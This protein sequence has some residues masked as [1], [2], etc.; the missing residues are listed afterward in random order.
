MQGSKYIQSDVN[1]VYI[2]IRQLLK[3]N[4]CVL[5][6]GTPCQVR[7]LKSFLEK[8]YTNLYTMDFLC[9]G[10]SSIKV[11]EK[12]L[13][14]SYPNKRVK[15]ISFRDK[16]FYGWSVNMHI[17]FDDETCCQINSQEDLWWKIYLDNIMLGTQ[18]ADNCRYCRN[19][20]A[21]ITVGDFWGIKDYVKRQ[22]YDDGRGTSVIII[23]TEKGQQIFNNGKKEFS[24]C[25]TVSFEE[26]SRRN[27]LSERIIANKNK[28]KEFFIRLNSQR[29]DQ[30]YYDIKKENG[31]V[32][33]V[34]L[35]F[36]GNYGGALTGWALYKTI[37]K[38]GYTPLLIDLEKGRSLGSQ[39]GMVES[40]IRSCCN[41][42]KPYKDLV[43]LKELN[44]K[45]KTFLV[46][47]DQCWRM[48]FNEYYDYALLLKFVDDKNR[49]LSFATSMES[50]YIEGSLE[51]RMIVGKLLKRFDQIS[52]RERDSVSFLKNQYN[53]EAEFVLDPIFLL[54]DEEWGKLTD[55]SLCPKEQYCA[56][57]FLDINESLLEYYNIIKEKLKLPFIVLRGT[58]SSNPLQIQF[59]KEIENASLP[60]MVNLIKEAKYLVT[61][62][63]HGMCLAIVF[64]IP[65]TV[66]INERRGGT[67]FRS[68]L[69]EFNLENRAVNI[70]FPVEQPNTNE[71]CWNKVEDTLFRLQSFSKNWLCRALVTDI[72]PRITQSEDQFQTKEVLNLINNLRKENE[73]M[74]CQIAELQ[75]ELIRPREERILAYLSQTIENGAQIAYR[76]GGFHTVRLHSL[77]K[78]LL[79]IKNVSV[80]FVIDQKVSNSDLAQ[81][82]TI[83][84][85][86]LKKYHA[87]YILISSAKYRKEMLKELKNFDEKV[88]DIYDLFESELREGQAYYEL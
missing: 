78:S 53:V 4:K 23:N 62:S 33:I 10:V 51:E 66:I 24:K 85:G 17:S 84:V 47:S 34:G 27:I 50:A 87:D 8:D 77:I 83:A 76:G 39:T 16:T 22:K 60:Q 3:Q 43:D 70:T 20:G 58:D 63:F 69:R 48:W 7:A 82:P 86:E 29:L 88:I 57:Y 30:L 11:L 18:C 28:R 64:R 9:H 52:V 31:N 79:K 75:K 36:T 54:D 40:F 35:W 81:F 5:F 71:I 2:Q 68:L 6:S 67:R 41:I 45:C 12:Y 1:D 42:S 80:L 56:G 15:R 37:E 21:D 26:A 19:S 13:S 46:G 32:G 61:D 25:D 72:K 38:M 49:M 44:D 59:E 65:F 14:E 74:K 73:I 55:A